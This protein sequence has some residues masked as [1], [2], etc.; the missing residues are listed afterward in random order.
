[1]SEK[2]ISN[3]SE[4]EGDKQ[5]ESRHNE[6]CTEFRYDGKV[7]YVNNIATDMRDGVSVGY[8]KFKPDWGG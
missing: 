5:I 8:S 4:H 7:F 1:M 3:M 6:N 2:S